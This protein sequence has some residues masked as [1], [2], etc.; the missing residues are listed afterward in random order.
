M[1]GKLLF[2]F[3]LFQGVT[4]LLFGQ[5]AGIQTKPQTKK[6]ARKIK[7]SQLLKLEEEGVPSFAKHN[8]YGFKLNG[9]GWGISYERGKAKS[10]YNATI[11]Q[12]EFNEKQHPKE[13]KQSSSQQSGG[14]VFLGN[15]F[16]YGK[17]NI[18]YQLKAGAG[19]QRMIGGKGN[20]NGVA[21]YGVLAGGLSIGML[22]PY[23]IEVVDATGAT[24]EIKYTPAD[25]ALF[26]SNRIVGGTGLWT[27]WGEMKFKPGVHAKAA[28]RFDYGRFNNFISALE[29]GFNFEYYFSDI[30]Q[31]V[32][33]EPKKFFPNFYFS[34]LF[35]RRK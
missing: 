32:N 7:N 11:L 6:E 21:V 14:A 31:L 19:T 1:K 2:I 13:D 20:K 24:K 12:F 27:G 8:L 18:F 34:I 17:Q 33:V 3:I 4:S 23:Y 10:P 16:V 35:G 26:L 15:P 29:G 28:L 30:E 5:D 25:S 22:R 9:D